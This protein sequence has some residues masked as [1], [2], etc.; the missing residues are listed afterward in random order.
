MERPRTE[1]PAPPDGGTRNEIQLTG[2]A[3][4]LLLMVFVLFLDFSRV[5]SGFGGSSEK[6]A[7]EQQ[8]K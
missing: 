7:A 8:Q 2:L 5:A 1:W 3:V 6:P 4:I